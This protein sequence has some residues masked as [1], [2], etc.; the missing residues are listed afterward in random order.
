MTT[1]NEV[2][3]AMKVGSGKVH[4]GRYFASGRGNGWVADCTGRI[5]G[6]DHEVLT[7]SA[8]HINCARCIA[9]AQKAAA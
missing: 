4:S 8:S 1:A 3:G 7:E 5:I 9:K 2:V 6:W